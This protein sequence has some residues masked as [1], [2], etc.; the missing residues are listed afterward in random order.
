MQHRP[1]R[2]V[3]LPVSWRAA[4]LPH[5]AEG[6]T[7]PTAAGLSARF[8]V[9]CSFARRLQE[10]EFDTG[11]DTRR[12]AVE[13]SLPACRK[14]AFTTHADRLRPRLQ[15]GRL[16]VAGPAARC[17]AGR[18]R[19]RRHRTRR[20]DKPHGDGRRPTGGSELDGAR[21]EDRRRRLGAREHR[22]GATTRQWL[23]TSLAAVA[24][25]A[26]L[27]AIPSPAA[28]AVSIQGAVTVTL[29]VQ[30]PPVIAS[31][32][33]SEAVL[34]MS[35]WV[36]KNLPEIPPDPNYGHRAS[37]RRQSVSFYR[38]CHGELDQGDLVDQAPWGMVEP[39]VTICRPEHATAPAGRARYAPI[40]QVDRPF[41][42]SNDKTETVHARAKWGRVIV[43]WH[44]CE[45]DKAA[46]KSS[47]TRAFVAVAPIRP[48][49][50][51]IS[52]N[53]CGFP[54]PLPA[55]KKRIRDMPGYSGI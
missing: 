44:G 9:P 21:V 7:G 39:S 31:P 1:L 8:F 36:R 47:R 4:G 30:A 28:A 34:R 23:H 53:F 12:R 25:A 42:A 22:R 26:T 6:K 24:V 48:L 45:I 46:Q 41:C 50:A 37:R 54:T 32:P 29:E 33:P 40:A 55:N 3:G 2:R 16:L 5:V 10:R 17:A 14:R 18:G 27:A 52:N 49:V 35:E 51:S 20:P 43:L 19:R 15:G 11:Y 13:A 38:A